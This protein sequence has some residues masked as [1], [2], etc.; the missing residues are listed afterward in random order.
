MATNPSAAPTE[1]AVLAAIP[2]PATITA[3]DAPKFLQKYQAQVA[4]M[5][6]FQV[7]DTASDIRCQ[8]AYNVVAGFIADVTA[9]FKPAKSAAYTAHKAITALEAMFTGPAELV[10]ANLAN[11]HLSWARR[12]NE[13]RI[14]EEQRLKREAEAKAEAQ[15]EALR[16]QL[17]AEA[18]AAHAREVARVADLPPWEQPE[19][20][21]PAEAPA[22]LFD[23]PEPDIPE[24]RLPSTVP[25]VAGGPSTRNLPWKCQLNDFKAMVIW[26]GK[27]CEAG[28]D[29]FLECLL[30]NMVRL[31]QL[32]RDHTTAL[33]EIIPGVEA[34]REQTLARG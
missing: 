21:L 8:D 17:Q 31:N 32:S 7:T 3:P 1:S 29:R 25:V 23:F 4:P 9:A 11:Q 33:K 34:V 15:R 30:P 26:I 14:A 6:R 13:L 2:Q 10:K 18:D 27:Q 12:C 19:A 24:I 20:D 28:D 22:V 5:G 16:R